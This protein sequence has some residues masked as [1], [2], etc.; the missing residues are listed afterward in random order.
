METE[1]LQAGITR[2]DFCKGLGLGLAALGLGSFSLEALAQAPEGGEL[3]DPASD[4]T[5]RA[6]RRIIETYEL[7]E[8]DFDP[9]GDWTHTYAIYT[10]A[11]AILWKQN[12][13]LTL[14]RKLAPT[15]HLLTGSCSRPGLSGYSHFIQLEA[16]CLANSLG[17]ARSWKA[18]S[19]MATAIDQPA[20][21][22]TGG[23]ALGKASGRAIEIDQGGGPSL[24]QL[25]RPYTLRW[26]L[27]E[28][29]QRLAGPATRPLDFTLVD[30]YDSLF[31]NQLLYFHNQLRLQLAGGL[32]VL[33]GYAHTGRGISYPTVYWV[34]ESG[35]LVL[36]FSGMDVW[37]LREENG[38]AIPYDD[39]GIKVADF[40]QQPAGGGR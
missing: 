34:D 24:Y 5:L 28:A 10:W 17:T 18:T 12:S 36:C 15:G 31:P 33:T 11:P 35:R 38:L 6:L 19:K 9:R 20:Y 32:Q 25:S 21:L 7:P 39:K 3:D 16:D 26:C 1:P 29:V 37:V 13:E 8:N 14:S 2:K 23:Q 40:R 30:E 27:F 22:M 4:F